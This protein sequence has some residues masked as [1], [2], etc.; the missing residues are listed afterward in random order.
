MFL[1]SDVQFSPGVDLVTDAQRLPFCD[2]SLG[3]VVT[4]DVLHHLEF[5]IR[6][7]REAARVLRVGGRVVL[8]EPG[9]TV[10]SSLFYR[11]LHREPVDMSANPLMDG[12]PNPV[13]D[14]YAS[15]QAIPTLLAT[16]YRRTLEQAVPQLQLSAV[17]W[18][19][20]FTYPLSGGFQR[21]SL[22]SPGMATYGLAVERRRGEMVRPH[23]W[24]QIV[25]SIGPKRQC[26]ALTVIPTLG[27][28]N[29]SSLAHHAGTEHEIIG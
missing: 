15:N 27:N 7:L 17:E 3:N 25:A 28:A 6:F 29:Y 12:E 9:I 16:R 11:Y 4:V 18:F 24:I 21:W 10:G 26:G 20:L 1:A 2:R 19:S 5:P 23:V 14:P 8:V 22:I 13:R